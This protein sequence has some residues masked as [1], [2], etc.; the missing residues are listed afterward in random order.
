MASD[1]SHGSEGSELSPLEAELLGI[2][3]KAKGGG[4]EGKQGDGG[5]IRKRAPK[6]NAAYRLVDLS[7]VLVTVVADSCSQS[8]MVIAAPTLLTLLSLF[9]SGTPWSLNHVMQQ[10]PKVGRQAVPA[11]ISHCMI[12]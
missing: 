2:D 10:Y 12:L 5:K 7:L 9:T 4:K 6:V 11:P 8:P 3:R 1:A